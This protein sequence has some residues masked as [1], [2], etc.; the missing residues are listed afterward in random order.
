[1]NLGLKDYASRQYLKESL[2]GRRGDH[3]E[4]IHPGLRTYDG[5]YTELKLFWRGIEVL[6]QSATTG[7]A[8]EDLVLLV[9]PQS[10]HRRAPLL[11][12]EQI[13]RAHV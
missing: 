1:M 7:E 13:G 9:T 2:I 12:V 3:D 8:Q 5:T 6:V 11:I 4:R 10:Q